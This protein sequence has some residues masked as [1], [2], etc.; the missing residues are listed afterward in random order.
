[1]VLLLLFGT[2]DN[3]RSRWVCYAKRAVLAFAGLLFLTPVASAQ[4]K[5][6]SAAHDLLNH[7]KTGID[8][9]SALAN[10]SIEALQRVERLAAVYGSRGAFE[11][12]KRLSSVPFEVFKREFESVLQEVEPLLSRLPQS[13][14]KTQVVNALYSYRDGVFWWSRLHQPLTIHVS[15]LSFAEVTH[16]PSDTAHAAT[17]P[18]TVAIHWRQASKHLKRAK[19]LINSEN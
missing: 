14:L 18:Y 4:F 9:A 5:P 15:L 7:P 3:H 2:Q 10:R 8:E 11:E 6:P 19:Q 17:L 1:M 13:P 16:T 12:N